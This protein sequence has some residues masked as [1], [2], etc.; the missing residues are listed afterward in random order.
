MPTDP[1]TRPF[2]RRLPSSVVVRLDG[3]YDDADE[4]DP[5]VEDLDHPPGRIVL[6]LPDFLADSL[7]H[8]IE[9]VWDVSER[10]TGGEPYDGPTPDLAEALHA[11]VLSQ[12]GYRCRSRDRRSAADNSWATSKA[13]RATLRPEAV[14]RFDQEFRAALAE[15]A[16]SFDLAPVDACVHRWRQV[17]RSSTDPTA[18]CRLQRQAG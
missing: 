2:Y 14:A 5:A 13:L 6:E 10:L 15:A 17:A 11:A 16:A 8:M 1:S 7:A 3:I 12:P 4:L 9:T 18:G